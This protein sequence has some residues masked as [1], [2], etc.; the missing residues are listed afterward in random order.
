MMDPSE[1]PKRQVPYITDLSVLLS[2]GLFPETQFNDNEEWL[3][4]LHSHFKVKLP[5]PKL[6]F[7]EDISSNSL[8]NYFQK[9][10]VDVASQLLARI[11][12]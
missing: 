7:E 1:D 4:R 3:S 5:K 9:D 8:Y 11:K 10:H 6:S 2:R 12:K